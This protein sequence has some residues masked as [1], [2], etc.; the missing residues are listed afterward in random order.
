MNK[1]WCLNEKKAISRIDS[2]ECAPVDY[3]E[4]VNHIFKV[5]FDVLRVHLY[6]NYGIVVAARV[7]RNVFEEVL[8]NRVKPSC[9]YILGGGVYKLGNLGNLFDCVGLELQ[10]YVVDSQKSGVLRSYRVLR[11]S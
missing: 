7:E 8:H 3:S 6:G 10:V 4:R 2:F 9:A 11:L 1:Q 5:L